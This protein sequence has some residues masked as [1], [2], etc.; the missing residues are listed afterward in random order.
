MKL[1]DKLIKFRK[2]AGFTQQ[3][4]A[5]LIN[6][7]R[8]TY[9]GYETGK[10]TIPIRK[11]QL[12]SVIYNLDLNAFSTNDVVE[13]NSDAAVFPEEPEEDAFDGE[14]DNRITREE[15]MLL[16]QMRLIRA[17]GKASELEEVLR[18]MTDPKL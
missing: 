13:L 4:I 2:E 11:L 7:E 9:T 12:L 14:I 1:E 6:V 10:A 18:R 5:D 8:S 3:Q 17:M 15:R 16:A